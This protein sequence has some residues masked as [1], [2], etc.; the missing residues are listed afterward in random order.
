MINQI[1]PS[2][3]R[4]QF[5]VKELVYLLADQVPEYLCRNMALRLVY[6][7][8]DLWVR[9]AGRWVCLAQLGSVCS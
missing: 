6:R 4:T 7:A 5:S 3:R 9:V 2:I 8:E 1:N